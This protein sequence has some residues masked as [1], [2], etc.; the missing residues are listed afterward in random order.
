MSTRVAKTKEIKGVQPFMMASQITISTSEFSTRNL[1]PYFQLSNKTHHWDLVILGVGYLWKTVVALL[2][3]VED[4]QEGEVDLWEEV[5]D[6][7][8]EADP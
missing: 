5:V 3:G 8:V 1:M 4:H 2:V 7:Q 6:H